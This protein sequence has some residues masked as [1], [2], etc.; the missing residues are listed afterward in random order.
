[1]LYGPKLSTRFENARDKRRPPMKK[2]S[3]PAAKQIENSSEQKLDLGGRSSWLRAS[4]AGR[5]TVGA[6]T[7]DDLEGDARGIQKYAAA[8]SRWKLGCTRPGVNP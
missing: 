2:I 3:A 5:S 7:G 8:G 1:M 6:E 4:E